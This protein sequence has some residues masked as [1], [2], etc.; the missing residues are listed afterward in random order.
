MLDYLTNLL[1]NENYDSASKIGLIELLGFYFT[2]STV[3][4]RGKLGE[5]AVHKVDHRQPDKMETFDLLYGSYP[6]IKRITRPI[7]KE[8]YYYT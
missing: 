4:L 1:Q 5:S 3:S 6:D 7:T 8:K 2:F